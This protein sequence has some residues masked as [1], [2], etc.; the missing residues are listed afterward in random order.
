MALWGSLAG[1]DLLGPGHHDI[2]RGC[3]RLLS[4]ARCIQIKSSGPGSVGQQGRN[5]GHE[6][7]PEGE[8]YLYACH[9]SGFLPVQ[10]VEEAGEGEAGAQTQQLPRCDGR[11]VHGARLGGHTCKVSVLA[12][13]QGCLGPEAG[14]SQHP[15]P[16][17][18]HVP[19]PLSPGRCRLR[20]RPAHRPGWGQFSSSTHKCPTG[21]ARPSTPCPD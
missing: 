16:Q 3:S 18:S 10:V 2:S 4:S 20:A 7:A 17:G 6:R 15:C 9:D 11:R 19:L 5:S 21:P 12:G 8:G 13:G 14:M 1:C